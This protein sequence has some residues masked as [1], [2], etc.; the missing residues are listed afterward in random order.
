MIISSKLEGVCN[1]LGIGSE[2]KNRELYIQEQ[3]RNIDFKKFEDKPVVIK[4]CFEKPIDT[5]NYM[6]ITSLLKPYC[7]S[8][9]YGEPCS[10][11]PVYKAPKKQ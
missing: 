8:I 1:Y 9:M 2:E 6:L 7:K 11:V 4:G 3:I 10:T 5:S